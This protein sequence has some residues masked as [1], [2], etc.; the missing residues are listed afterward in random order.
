MQKE[1]QD[2]RAVTRHVTLEGVN[3]LVAILPQRRIRVAAWRQVLALEN[4][5]MNPN[6][7]EFLIVGAIENADPAAFGKDPR[8]TPEI[9]VR[10][11]G[12]GRDLE[13]MDVDTLRVYA[14]HHVFDRAVLSRRIRPLKYDENRVPT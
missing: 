9:V 6:D 14:R 12:R 5:R 3:V 7:H 8:C 13:A 2:Q 11:L 4:R 10:E 1:F